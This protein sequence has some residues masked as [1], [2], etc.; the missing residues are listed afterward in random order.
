MDEMVTEHIVKW[1]DIVRR[2]RTKVDIPRKYRAKL[3]AQLWLDLRSKKFF[4][5]ENNE[6]VWR[7]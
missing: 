1:D 5:E 4:I 7:E 3:G 2:Y 6:V